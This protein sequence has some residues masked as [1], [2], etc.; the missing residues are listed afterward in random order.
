M[1]MANSADADQTAPIEKK[2]TGG[3]LT[4]GPYKRTFNFKLITDYHFYTP[5]HKK[6]RGIMLYPPNFECPSVRPSVV[7]PSVCP[8]EH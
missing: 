8:G 6:W 2:K 3:D 1:R 5:P 4:L 7:R